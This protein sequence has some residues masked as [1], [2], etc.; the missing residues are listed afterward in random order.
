M[1]VQF[2]PWSELARLERDFAD[3]FDGRKT[4]LAPLHQNGDA[5]RPT[6]W[7]PS[8]DVQEDA[9]KIVLFADLPGL[10]QKDV[11]IRVEDQLLTLRGE[12]KAPVGEA[13][14]RRERVSG[15]FSR[16][17]TLP[18]TVDAEKISAEMKAGVLTLTLPKRAEAQ[19]RQIKI[20]IA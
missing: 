11:E 3:F 10:D 20:N 2:R 14:L 6:K 1:L 9:H 5:A 8:V 13:G 18:P 15:S 4:K 16:A 7:Q 19:P 12:R 17:F